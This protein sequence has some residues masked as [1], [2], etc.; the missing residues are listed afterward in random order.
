VVT[1]DGRVHQVV[2]GGALFGI[3][4]ATRT[5]NTLITLHLPRHVTSTS[6]YWLELK[7]SHP[8]GTSSF[9][10]TDQLGAPPG[11]FIEFNT[12]PRVGRQVYVGA[13]SCLQWHGYGGAHQLYLQSSG[14]VPPSDFSV[15]LVK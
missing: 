8:L 3:D 11:H 4:G 1:Q 5:L 14:S 2:E 13:G 10:L 12:L 6:F 7:G 9:A 15:T